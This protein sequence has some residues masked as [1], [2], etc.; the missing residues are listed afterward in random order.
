MASQSRISTPASRKGPDCLHK[1]RKRFVPGAKRMREEVKFSPLNVDDLSSSDE[2]EDLKSTQSLSNEKARTR[3]PLP[4]RSDSMATL[5]NET[6]PAKS[7]IGA[8]GD[9]IDIEREKARPF[10]LRSKAEREVGRNMPDYSDYEEDVTAGATCPQ[11]PRDSPEWSPAFLH[12]HF[13]HSAQ[14]HTLSPPAKG[15]SSAN[16]ATYASSHMLTTSPLPYT[17]VPA[18][19]SLI[20]AIDRISAAQ[21]A[22]YKPLSSPATPPLMASVRDGLPIHSGEP[23][24]GLHGP[25]WELFWKDVKE[26]AGN[27]LGHGLA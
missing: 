1:R 3:R 2:D 12:R 10:Q 23:R 17:P 6:Q 5:V 25:K 9:V 7:I 8:D 11:V 18:T 21:Q 24:C 4:T 19:P 26:K 13:A 16:S 22:A 14:P 27:G 15:L 20:R